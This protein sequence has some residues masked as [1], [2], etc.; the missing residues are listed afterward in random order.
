MFHYSSDAASWMS[1]LVSAWHS[2]KPSGPAQRLAVWIA[3]KHAH[4]GL[5]TRRQEADPGTKSICVRSS[6][7]CSLETRGG[8]SSSTAAIILP[9]KWTK[10][11]PFNPRNGIGHTHNN[12]ANQGGVFEVICHQIVNY[13][14]LFVFSKII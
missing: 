10:P 2:V 9:S 3:Q 6:L 12:L 8:A 4:A 5:N 1:T 11:V 14:R 13:L 7:S